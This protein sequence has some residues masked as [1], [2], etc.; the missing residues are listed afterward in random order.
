M[1]KKGRTSLV[2]DSPLMRKRK[3]CS[4]LSY[5]LPEILIF[6][7]STRNI[8]NFNHIQVQYPDGSHKI[9]RGI[10]GNQAKFLWNWW[11]ILVS[12]ISLW[13]KYI[14]SLSPYKPVTG[15]YRELSG[16]TLED[17]CQKILIHTLALTLKRAYKTEWWSNWR[18]EH[19]INN[20]ASCLQTFP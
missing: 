5:N 19:R 4:S 11:Y 16:T 17:L 13:N 18:S 15:L 1:I 2:G 8:Q 3:M 20:R 14:F 12:P 9:C 6:T 7:F 10:K